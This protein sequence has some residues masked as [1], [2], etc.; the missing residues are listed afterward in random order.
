MLPTSADNPSSGSPRERILD[1]ADQ[2]FYTRGINSVGVDTI[3]DQ[4]GAAKTTL[5]AQFG[6]KDGL[7]AAYLRNRSQRWQADLLRQLERRTRQPYQRL[8]AVFEILGE[9]CAAPGFRGC[10][11]INA[12]AELAD[13]SHPG[14]VVA[15]Q[16]RAWVRN[17]LRELAA[18][19][20][21][22]QPANVASELQLLYDAVLV[23]AQ[24]EDARQAAHRARHAAQAI[25]NTQVP[26]RGARKES[27]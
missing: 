18:A 11:F 17:L 10:P 26:Q 25:L 22:R 20:G 4:S 12:T 5:Y 15:L 13:P 19:A 8:L 24:V 2:L 21:C 16:H 23:S 27:A 6:S 7:I 3:V 1:I 14:R 9:A